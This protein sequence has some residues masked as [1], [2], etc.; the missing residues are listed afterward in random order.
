MAGRA[1]FPVFYHQIDLA[2]RNSMFKAL[3]R[4]GFEPIS[5]YFPFSEFALSGLMLSFNQCSFR[6]S[7]EG[8]TVIE[9]ERR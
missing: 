6:L 4:I 1:P 2:G 8:V 9:T 5:S 3:S 7:I